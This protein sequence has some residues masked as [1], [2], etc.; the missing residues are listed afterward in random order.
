[1]SDWFDDID[2][3]DTNPTIDPQTGLIVSGDGLQSVFDQTPGDALFDLGS[4]LDP[5]AFDFSNVVYNAAS[6]NPPAAANGVVANVGG[7]NLMQA[8]LQAL[9]LVGAYKAAG[10]PA[11]RASSATTQVNSNGTITTRNTAGGATTVQMPAGT[12]YL[13]SNGTLVTN[14]GNGTYTTVYPDGHQT[15]NAYSAV[16]S[17]GSLSTLLQGNTPLYIGG[18]LLAVLLL[19]RRS[20]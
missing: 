6:P 15:I 16:G 5:S 19:S 2:N 20:S 7:V 1:M 12:P 10:Q 3:W 17:L 18:A 9:Q 13:A 11:V 4:V 8:A 14:N